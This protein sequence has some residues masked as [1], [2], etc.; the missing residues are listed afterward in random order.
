MITIYKS[1]DSGSGVAAVN[2]NWSS[3]NENV[4]TIEASEEGN[5]AWL[6]AVGLGNAII[7]VSIP[8]VAEPL[9]CNITVNPINQT[10]PA[11]AGDWFTPWMGGYSYEE[12]EW[13]SYD[14]SVVSLTEGSLKAENVGI[15]RVKASKEGS[16][17]GQYQIQ[18]WAV[19]LNLPKVDGYYQ[20]VW[21]DN[22]TPYQ[23]RAT[24]EKPYGFDFSDDIPDAVGS[25]SV[26]Y[27]D[28]FSVTSDGIV[29]GSEVG[30]GAIEAYGADGRRL[31]SF[32]VTIY[33]FS[34]SES[35][36]EVPVGSRLQLEP[37]F[38]PEYVSVD[39][40]QWYGDDGCVY[41]N[42]RGRVTANYLGNASVFATD[43]NGAKASCNITVYSTEL[44]NTDLNVP[45]Y[46][47]IPITV[48]ATY[49]NGDARTLDSDEIYLISDNENIASIVDGKVYGNSLGVTNVNVF[50]KT[51]NKYLGSCYVVV[52]EFQLRD[53]NDNRIDNRSQQLPV[54][55]EYV[56]YGKGVS[57]DESSEE[58]TFDVRINCTL[59]EEGEKYVNIWQDNYNYAWINTQDAVGSATITAT[60]E[61]GG[62]AS[63]NVDVFKVTLNQ[64]EP[65]Y[66][67]VGNKEFELAAYAEYPW[68]TYYTNVYWESNNTDLAGVT[69][70]EGWNTYVLT[71]ENNYVGTSTIYAK[72]IIDGLN[73]NQPVNVAECDFIV[74]KLQINSPSGENSMA[75]RDEVKL[76]A[77]AYSQDKYGYYMNVNLD[78]AGLLPIWWDS[79]DSNIAS[80]SR[81]AENSAEC[82]VTGVGDGRVNINA[83]TNGGYYERGTAI[84]EVRSY[85]QYANDVTLDQT[86]LVLSV[87]DYYK[88]D[89][90]VAPAN[91]TDPTVIWSLDPD[92]IVTE[93]GIATI[94]DEGFVTAV[95]LGTTTLYA[96]CKGGKYYDD[97]YGE[98]KDWYVTTTCE[99][100][101]IR[102]GVESVVLSEES[103]DIKVGDEVIINAAVLPTS[104]T[105]REVFWTSSDES[106]ATVNYYGKVVGVGPGVATITATAGLVSATCEVT[107]SSVVAETLSITPDAWNY[108]EGSSFTITPTV[109]PFNT[110]DKEVT[111]VSS[112]ESIAT[113]SEDGI[114]T[115]LKPGTCTIS[116]T[117]LDGSDITA[118]CVIT[119]ETGVD[120]IFA[121]PNANF[122][123]YTVNGVVVKK[124]CTSEDLKDLEPAI[125]V[126]RRGNETKTVYLT[127]RR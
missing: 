16:I 77:S 46:K 78:E 72:M 75:I 39:I 111:F 7:N 122:D 127:G 95:G 104:A 62:S 101:V 125:Y 83:Y 113:V 45:L 100:T 126:I 44:D 58:F 40:K 2:A 41:V 79:D 89:A 103:L 42:S 65:K 3:T 124:N 28:G 96:K 54:K 25:W 52:Y 112:D 29:T 59:S 88:L 11:K 82:T 98:Y 81:N 115:I 61:Y 5:E 91:T 106:V 12:L 15:T 60:D 118:S 10:F 1:D 67:S 26:N 51:T 87:G 22:N 23:L 19:N 114:V 107:V 102:K 69:E 48:T 20:L 17:I 30:N 85:T 99:L 70:S 27:G 6:R 55:Q 94:N 73:D 56:I 74:Y 43:D 117:T 105:E 92:R 120:G 110:T 32:P 57:Y 14:E 33:N 108:V 50:H 35:N 68:G 21:P 34:L 86:N 116:V 121:D 84:K 119:G 31:T 93:N 97:Y 53:S 4:A 13:Y 123:V 18:V 24:I 76:E 36:V 80:I 38:D 64:T 9:T 49:A 37:R 63:F 66:L 71:N 90:T 8:G 47:T 109:E